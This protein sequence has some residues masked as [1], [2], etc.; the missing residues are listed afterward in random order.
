MDKTW[1]NVT[2]EESSTRVGYDVDAMEAVFQDKLEQ[3]LKLLIE[4]NDAN[5]LAGLVATDKV[6]K[7]IIE[8]RNYA[9]KNNVEDV[10]EYVTRFVPNVSLNTDGNTPRYRFGL[11]YV[12]GRLPVGKRLPPDVFKSMLKTKFYAMGEG[13]SKAEKWNVQLLRSEPDWVQEEMG[14]LDEKFKGLNDRTRLVKEI[15]NKIY[16]LSR[17]T[18]RY[19]DI[20]RKKYPDM[21][22]FFLQEGAEGEVTKDPESLVLNAERFRE[23]VKEHTGK[24]TTK[25]RSQK[26]LADIVEQIYE[27]QDD[28]D[29]PFHDY[30][31]RKDQ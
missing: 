9:M 25:K 4:L 8:K 22:E 24:A 19:H 6:F 1:L 5:Y 14:D 27:N 3:I 11:R 20:D 21:D 18:K 2:R 29:R 26:E 12:A 10:R 17:S 16:E 15:R 7:T 28:L 30:R 13:Q 23:I 31:R